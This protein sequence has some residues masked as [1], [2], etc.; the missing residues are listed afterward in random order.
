ME[1]IGKIVQIIGTVID[2]EFQKDFVPTID[3]ALEVLESKTILEVVQILDEKTVR[4]LAMKS[5]EGL[6]RGMEVK[7]LSKNI[8]V[9]VGK[10][11]LGRVL[12]VIGEP[13]DRKGPLLKAK[14][15][16]IHKEAPKFEEQSTSFEL[17]ETGIKA[18][19]LLC[20]FPKG[21]KIGLF[22]GAGVGKTMLIMELMHNI[23]K[24]HGGYSI[25]AGVGERIREGYDLYQ[26]MKASHVIEDKGGESKAALV[27]G[28]M[29]ETAGARKNAALTG[30]TM[31]EYFRDEEGLDVLLFIDNIFRFAQAGSEVSALMGRLPSAVGYQPTLASDL[32]KL[33]ERITSTKE[34]SI[35]SIQAIYVPADDLTD[36]APLTTFTHLDATIVLSRQVAEQGI[37]PAIDALETTSRALSPENVSKEHYLIA[38]KVVETLEK[39]HSLQDIIAILGLEELSEE[40]KKVVKRARRIALFLSQPFQVAENFTGRKGVYVSL[41]ETLEGFK[42]I[43]DGKL[44]EEPEESFFMKGAL[45][46]SLL[47]QKA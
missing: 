6:K 3:S 22:G 28:Q 4:T 41:Q 2:V 29:N 39:Y 12:N 30:V 17:L 31:A 23:S 11:V 19:D 37:Y 46:D 1:Q 18:I 36:P 42:A 43:L 38:T 14:R 32:G 15:R 25:F 33:Q 21:G 47:K 40:D 16:P 9:P 35:T 10:A 7:F 5:T 8:E 45:P 34:G 26:E 27:F 13:I 20:P 44:D 24:A